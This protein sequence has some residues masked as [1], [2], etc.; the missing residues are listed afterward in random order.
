MA[1]IEDIAGGRIGFKQ[2]S[3][4]GQGQVSHEGAEA[5]TRLFGR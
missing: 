1:L 4:Y 2:R 5:Y 3:G